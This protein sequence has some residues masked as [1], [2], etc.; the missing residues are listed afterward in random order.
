MVTQ[1]KRTV[2]SVE[3]P[4]LGEA[5]A[6]VIEAYDKSLR[7]TYPDLLIGADQAEKYARAWLDMQ[8]ERG[9]RICAKREYDLAQLAFENRK[10]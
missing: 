8:Y 3:L 4:D 6:D 9:K 5:I 2:L 10:Q 1:T 7:E